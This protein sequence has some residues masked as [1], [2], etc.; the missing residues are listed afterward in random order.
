VDR[1]PQQVQD[2][3]GYMPQRFGLYE[4]LTVQENLNLYADLNN[5]SVS[6]RRARYPRL[7]E[8]TALGPF[9]NRLAGKLS[10]G[11]KQ[12]LGLA[13]TLV[14]APELLL[15]DE[16]TVGVDPLSRREL[17]AIIQQLTGER[18]LTV[19]LSTAYL[20]EAQ[21]CDDAIVL[22]EGRVLAQRPP[23]EIS[24]LADGHAFLLTPR[25]GQT[26]RGLQA[27][28]L[29]KP[30]VVDAVPEGGQ[31]RL[32]VGGNSEMEV[33]AEYSI[34]AAAERAPPRFEDGFMM[35]LHRSAENPLLA[36]ELRLAHRPQPE[37]GGPVV[38]VHELVRKFGSFTAVD[39]ISFEVQQGEVFGLLGPNG[40]GKTTTFRMLCGL[41]PA[42]SGTLRVAGTDLRTARASARQRIGY[43]A[44]KFSL[45]GQL[46]VVE[47]LAFFC[48]A[49]GLRGQQRRERVRWALD[50]FELTPFAQLPSSQLPGGYKQRLAMAVAL[51]HEPAILFLDEPTS[52]VDPLARR[53]F[54]QRITALAEQ[55]VTVI[56]TT[57]FMEEAEYCDRVAILDAGRILAQGTPAELRGYAES[58][59]G[60]DS[61]MESAFIAIVENSRNGNG[62]HADQ[63]LADPPIDYGPE[64]DWLP[65]K[66]RRVWSLVKKE[67]RQMVRD[68]SS[69]AIGIVL[70]VILILLFG[71]GLS[72]D[73]NNIPLAVVMEE[74]S[75]DAVDLAAGFQL[76]PYFE[77]VVMTSMPRARQMMQAREIDAIVRIQSDFGRDLSLGEAEVQI[78]VQGTDANRARIIQAYLQGAVGSWTLRR[79][80]EGRAVV[81]GPV[82]I[83]DRLWFNEAN[84]SRYFLVPGLIV[85]IMTL[86][87]S[88]L[89]TLV[90][91]R[92]WERGTLEALFVTP[93][94]VGEIL[95][96]KTIPNF[97]LGMIGLGLCIVTARFLFHVPLRGS[98]WL[99]TASSM[100][101]LVVALAVGLLISVAVKSQFVASQMTILITFLPA[102]MLSG[103][104]F[105]L[106]NMPVIVQ[107]ITYVL[108][109]RYFVAV[110]QTVFLAGNIWQVILPST[111][112]LTVMAVLLLIAVRLAT[113]KKLA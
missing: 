48:G 108:P 68:A 5:V 27:R 96:G 7:M 11:M 21:R 16:P 85:L 25:G 82:A 24:R 97:A 105:D 30:G 6:D 49:Y 112:V 56:V 81:S 83:R 51:V 10:G 15:L 33:A 4:D 88:F 66:G 91:A 55:G 2:R 86:I 75:P 99:L 104:L 47:N 111:F 50:Q 17:W 80:A 43:V 73:V 102:L 40:A 20:D 74:P 113:Q 39:H 38:E 46:T 32:V 106:R 3:I 93:V 22:H 53:E 71:Y 61:T 70:P 79:A 12:K 19:L 54:W 31:V 95:L 110:L 23:S 87:G 8:M 26:A 63:R 64:L 76:S 77:P 98:L 78:L 59:P 36:H 100:L 37:R 57:H 89:T 29:G 103:F 72:L 90:M 18:N 67:S 84:E 65:P 9:V 52:G 35:L 60:E 44:Q 58:S 34:D 62:N 69:I 28:L 42:T 14:R 41:L 94:R 45:Y 92:E 109:A 101:Y 1:D 107:A 13:C